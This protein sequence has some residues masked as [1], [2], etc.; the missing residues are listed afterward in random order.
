MHVLIYMSLNVKH[1]FF[2]MFLKYS[3]DT[4]LQGRTR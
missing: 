2:K 1:V 4:E 3:W